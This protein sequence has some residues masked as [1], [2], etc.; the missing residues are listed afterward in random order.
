MTDQRS[1]AVTADEIGNFGAYNNFR[2]RIGERFCAVVNGV[3]GVISSACG[4]L[5]IEREHNGSITLSKR[6][7]QLLTGALQQTG[8]P[9]QGQLVSLRLTDNDAGEI[10]VTLDGKELRGWSYKDDTERRTKMLAAREY[11]EGWCD[12]RDIKC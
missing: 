6:A 7:A 1:S 2:N 12:G 11:V 5:R 10:S 4:D 8:I 9:A 3:N